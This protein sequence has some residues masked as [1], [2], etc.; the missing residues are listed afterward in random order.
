MNDNF[1][2]SARYRCRTC[3]VSSYEFFNEGLLVCAVCDNTCHVDHDVEYSHRGKAYCACGMDFAR[4][5]SAMQK[6]VLKAARLHEEGNS[7]DG[8]LEIQRKQ[9]GQS[10]RVSDEQTDRLG[11]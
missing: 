1:F 6:N 8:K 2:L 11:I 5:C 9:K 10:V 7:R 4:P 3:T